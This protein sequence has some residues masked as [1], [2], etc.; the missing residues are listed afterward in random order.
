[1]VG[2]SE[3]FLSTGAGTS[4][5]SYPII[6]AADTTDSHIWITGIHNANAAD[7]TVKKGSSATLAAS[8]YGTTV[9]KIKAGTS[10]TPETPI[11]LGIGQVMQTDKADVTFTFVERVAQSVNSGNDGV[12]ITGPAGLTFTSTSY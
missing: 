4:G 11:D 1:M 8:V 12:N 9:A 7:A 10:F 6:P 2:R 3:S 5:G